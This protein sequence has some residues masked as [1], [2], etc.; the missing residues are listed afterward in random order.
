MTALVLLDL[1]AVLDT[2][3]HGLT[4]EVLKSRFSFDGVALDWFKLFPDAR[5]SDVHVWRRY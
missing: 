1:S 5:Y 3:D 2:V 4:I